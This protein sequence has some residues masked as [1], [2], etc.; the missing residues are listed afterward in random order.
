MS[1]RA[2]AWLWLLGRALAGGIFAYA[3]FVKAAAP[4]AEFAYAIESYRV[5][6]PSF[7]MPAAYIL[8]W[9]ELVLG[10]FLPAGLF[11][12]IAAFLA[13]AM[14]VVFE[15]FLLSGMI[16]EIPVT[17]CGCFGASVASFPP[18]EFMLNLALLAGTLLS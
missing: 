12:R 1:G 3:G 13:G 14:L 8:P 5:L 6:S 4:A 7:A 18:R 10:L 16:R 11:T 2:Q 17:S 15:G 9:A